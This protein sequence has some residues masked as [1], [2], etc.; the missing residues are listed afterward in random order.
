MDGFQVRVEDVSRRG[1]MGHIYRCH[2]S[3]Q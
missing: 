1:F 3:P 2:Y